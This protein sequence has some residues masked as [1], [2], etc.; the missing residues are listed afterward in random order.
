VHS[1]QRISLSGPYRPSNPSLSSL[2]F[3]SLVTVAVVSRGRSENPRPDAKQMR[4]GIGIIVGVML[5]DLLYFKLMSDKKQQQ[6]QERILD[7]LVRVLRQYVTGKGYQPQTQKEL[8]E[9]LDIAPQHAT[10]FKQ[11]LN[12]LVEEG[13]L[14]RER[15]RY[16]VQDSC[17]AVVAGII[18]VHKRG[19]G[20]VQPDDT[21]LFPE[22]IFIPPNQ[23]G[24]AVDGDRVEAAITGESPSDK[25]PEGRVLAILERGRTHIAG[26]IRPSTQRDETL[27]YVPLLGADRVVEVNVPIGEQVR[28]GDR[29]VLAVKDWGDPS[30]P[31]RCQLSHVIGHISDPSKDIA[32]AIE[33]FDLRDAFPSRVKKEARRHGNRVPL[34]TIRERE[35]LRD[36]TC[37]TIDPE[38][39][40]DFDDAISLE[41][42][43]KGNFH[44]GVHI[45]DVSH[46]VTS[47]SWLDK[48]AR[49][50]CNST[51]FPGF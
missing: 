4:L 14:V 27:A 32:A 39:A 45:A 2:F 38:T 23:T 36:T 7:N 48:E 37:V 12:Y 35:D 42:D 5:R 25:G 20:F 15:R 13:I 8:S 24:T 22:D 44:L 16:C 49:T 51:Y 43:K 11:A 26:V 29:V 33:E 17:S 30:T 10:L 40:K 9:R 21:N 18:R 47:G 41:T 1:N 34:K 46:Y 28:V 19:F 3:L 6:K 50:R 31:V